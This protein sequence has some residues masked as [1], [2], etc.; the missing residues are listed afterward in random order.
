MGGGYAH[1]TKGTPAALAAEINKMKVQIDALRRQIVNLGIQIDTVDGKLIIGSGRSLEVDGSLDVTGNTIIGGTLSLPNGIINN[2]AL[3]APVSPANAHAD[4]TNFS[5]TTTY[6]TVATATIT[7][8]T[9]YSRALVMAVGQV[10]ATNSTTSPDYFYIGLKINGASVPGW[11]AQQDC[12]S[13][14]SWESTGSASSCGTAV[15][16]GLSGS[17]TIVLQAATAFYG[18]AASSANTANIDATMLFLR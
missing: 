8:P 4:A 6:H 17:F 12:P 16:T 18:W 1:Q 13:S 3:N 10:S 15:L 11:A 5:L 2:D 7:V 14:A 9:G